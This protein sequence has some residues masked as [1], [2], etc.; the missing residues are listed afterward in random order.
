[1]TALA[2]LK[3]LVLELTPSNVFT[4]RVARPA[5]VRYE[6]GMVAVQVV[7]LPQDDGFSVYVE[8]RPCHVTVDP[9][10]NP[11]P[12]MVSGTVLVLPALAEVGEKL[13]MTGAALMV[14]MEFGEAA[15]L[16]LPKLAGL[17]TV[18]EAVP[19]FVRDEAGTDATREVVLEYTLARVSAFHF[20]MDPLVKLVPVMVTVRSPLTPGAPAVAV[21]GARPVIVGA[22]PMLNTKVLEMTPSAVTTVMLPVPLVVRSAAGMVAVMEVAFT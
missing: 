14:N 20:T 5:V 16:T 1:M 11:V 19:T 6:A 18:M 7:R 17:I 8:F 21:C 22:L 15:E 10:E 4:L 9:V 3:L 2:T 12:V 13:V